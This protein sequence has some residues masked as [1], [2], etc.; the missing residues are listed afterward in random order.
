MKRFAYLMVS[1]SLLAAC[2][3]R[4]SEAAQGVNPLT[5]ENNSVPAIK[6]PVNLPSNEIDTRPLASTVSTATFDCAVLDSG[7]YWFGKGDLAQKASASTRSSFFDPSQPTMIYVHGW[8]AGSHNH[9]KRGTFN[10]SKYDPIYG[11]K[12][13]AADAW[14]DAGWNI[15]IFYWNQISDELSPNSAED[16]V[17]GTSDV[18]WKNCKGIPTALPQPASTVID[19]IYASFLDATKGYKGNN[20]RLAGHSLGNQ[21]VTKLAARLS[22][23]VTAGKIEANRLPKRVALIDPWWSAATRAQNRGGELKDVIQGLKSKGMIFEW[24]KT[25]N[26]NDNLRS[27]DNAE[28]LPII[29][30]TEIFP[31]YYRS[32]NNASR[33]MAAPFL[34]F[35]SFKSSSPDASPSAASSD[36]RALEWMN[37]AAQWQQVDGRETPI[38]TD[39]TF[40]LKTK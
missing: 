7:I 36:A 12:I 34:Y 25:S 19:L 16:K 9:E 38:T 22:D 1:L 30:R 35:L 33:H 2:N 27:N 21:V 6:P 3:K 14:I 39:N 11:V 32:A 17:W 13:D 29:G 28:L 5:G 15:G 4:K 40:E 24:Y 31:D 20:I 26:V 37:Q 18:T 8:Q 10:Y 23:D